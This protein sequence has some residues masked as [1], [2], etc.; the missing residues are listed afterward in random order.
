MRHAF[1]TECS[2]ALSPRPWAMDWHPHQSHQSQESKAA[3]FGLMAED[4]VTN[5]MQSLTVPCLLS[6]C[7][8]VR[9]AIT[10]TLIASQRQALLKPLLNTIPEPRKLCLLKNKWFACTG[11]DDTYTN[12][13]EDSFYNYCVYG[14]SSSLVSLN[15]LPWDL[16]F[17]GCWSSTEQPNVFSSGPLDCLILVESHW[18]PRPDLL[19]QSSSI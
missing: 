4:I 11:L 8:S 1:A 16:K 3:G 9:T 15:D 12:K 14:H 13:A 18:G 2:T 5:W 6:F 7:Q 10:T 17:S 19:G